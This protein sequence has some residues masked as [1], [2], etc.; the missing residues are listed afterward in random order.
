MATFSTNTPISNAAS[1]NMQAWINE[2][3]TAFVTTLGLTQTGDTGQMAVPCVSALPGGANTA[4]GY[5]VFA[6]N[7]TL[8]AS[9]PIY[10]KMECGTGTS[11]AVPGIFMTVGTGTNGA[12]TITGTVHPRSKWSCDG[13]LASTTN[14]YV[15]RFCYNTTQGVLWCAFKQG[16]NNNLVGLSTAFFGFCIYR[17]IDNTGAPTANATNILMPSNTTNGSNSGY[18]AAIDYPQAALIT[19]SNQQNW[20]YIPLSV[21]STQ[22]GTTA[23]VFPVF[24]YNGTATLPGWGLTN[25]CA[26]TIL[27]EISL[28]STATI[29]MVGALSATYIQVTQFFAPINTTGY[30]SPGA[31]SGTTYGCILL[32]Q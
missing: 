25:V 19:P 4:A 10:I 5:Y 11:T 14:N 6:F 15:S 26:L 30:T 9:A 12:G 32:W 1:A 8:Q 29:T 24:Q 7:D 28:G 17:S 13:A 3:Y 31:Y 16:V 18:F 23:Q 22:V 2:L 20:G 21:T 27:G